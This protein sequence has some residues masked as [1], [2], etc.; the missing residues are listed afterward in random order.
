MS[1]GATYRYNESV[2]LSGTYSRILFNDSSL[3][4]SRNDTGS[5]NRGDLTGQ[6]NGTVNIIGLQL[7]IDF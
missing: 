1:I 6:L 2:R 7:D 5:S 4:L 3:I